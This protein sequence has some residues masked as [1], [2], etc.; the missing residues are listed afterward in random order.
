M[1]YL[2][3]AEI[4]EVI[5]SGG[6]PLAVKDTLLFE[7]LD[8]LAGI[9]NRRIHTRAPITAPERITPE[10]VRGL[11]ERGPL[12][13]I[14]H[15]N[16]P[17][18]LGPDVDEALARLIQAGIPVL[19]QSVLLRGVNDD[20]AVLIALSEALVQR[21][22]FPYYLHH[23]DQVVG[24]QHFRVSLERGMAIYSD[25]KRQLSGLALPRYVIDQPDGT[26]KVDVALYGPATGLP[27]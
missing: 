1:R 20:P 13:V 2:N 15:V 21:N 24:N 16:H 23:T 7:V 27:G 3:T 8:H 25:M 4:S 26:G 10:L 12:W 14:V 19:N 9:A 17:D 11:A 5:L 6:D 18:E 22:V